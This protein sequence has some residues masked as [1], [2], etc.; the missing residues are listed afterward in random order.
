[1]SD[2]KLGTLLALFHCILQEPYDV[3]ITMCIL[4]MRTER[5]LE[6]QKAGFAINKFRNEI[7]MLQFCWGQV[8]GMS[9]GPAPREERKKLKWNAVTTEASADPVQ[10][11]K[12]GMSLQQGPELR[13]GARS[14]SRLIIMRFPRTWCNPE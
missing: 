3:V 4:Q 6:C 5:L 14:L 13:Q 10:R 2:S 7:F 11:A 12:A 1:M 8:R 9:P